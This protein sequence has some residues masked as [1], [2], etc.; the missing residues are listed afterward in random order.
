MSARKISLLLL[1]AAA[2]PAAGQNDFSSDP[3]CVAVYEFEPGALTTDSRGGN[4]LTPTVSPPTSETELFR[5]GAGCARFD[6]AEAQ[7]YARPDADLSADFP[8]KDGA[9]NHSFSATW[10]AYY[11]STSS[12]GRAICSKSGSLWVMVQNGAL[13][14]TLY[15][16]GVG[17]VDTD[18]A[19]TMDLE[20]WYFHALTYDAAT[21]QFLMHIWDYSAGDTLGLDRDWTGTGY[22]EIVETADEMRI[23]PKNLWD[24]MDGLLDEFTVWNRA[25]TIDEIDE[26]RTGTFGGTPAGGGQI[27]RVT[28]TE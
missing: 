22:G 18:H 16:D 6:A 2:W 17:T 14:C 11:E 7:Y 12:G 13:S 23:G 26:I 24:P 4:T 9:A 8:M 3:N 27:L 19:S 20:K 28:E 25:L 15:F 21:L 1:L 5:S 10:W